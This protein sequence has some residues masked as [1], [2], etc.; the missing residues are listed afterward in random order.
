VTDGKKLSF[1]F[2][3]SSDCW[4]LLLNEMWSGRV[5]SEEQNDMSI[6]G[7]AL[8]N[9]LIVDA[10]LRRLLPSAGSVLDDVM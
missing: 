2:R 6:R 4:C 8:Q 1:S 5:M 10:F 9:V 3:E 7:L